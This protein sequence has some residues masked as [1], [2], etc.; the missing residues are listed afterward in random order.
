MGRFFVFLQVYELFR[1]V[2]YQIKK[3]NI[4]GIV[5]LSPDSQQLLAENASGKIAFPDLTAICCVKNGFYRTFTFPD[6]IKVDIYL[7]FA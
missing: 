6:K 4:P 7:L 2:C 5:I 1:V 3:V